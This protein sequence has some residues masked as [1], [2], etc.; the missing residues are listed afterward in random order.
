LPDDTFEK[1]DEVAPDE[2]PFRVELTETLG[3][4]VS[5]AKASLANTPS[6]DSKI[7]AKIAVSIFD[8]LLIFRI[9]IPRL[10]H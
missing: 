9:L 8:L 7:T 2:D 1:L 5:C 10:N 3:R 6:D 4:V